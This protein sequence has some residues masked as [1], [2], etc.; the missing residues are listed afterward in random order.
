VTACGVVGVGAIGAGMVRS[1]VRAGFPVSAYDLDPGARARA[2]AAGAEP[3]ASLVEL[4][5]FAEV[6]LLALPDTP[7]IEAALDGG[8]EAGLR[9][10]STLVITSTVSPLTPLELER[11]LSPAGVEVLDA[12]VSGGPLR[13]GS[14]ELAIMV[15][16]SAAVFERRRPVLE[17]L[18]SHLVHVGPTGQGEIAKLVNNLMGAVIVLGIAEGLSLAAA[19]GADVERLCDAVAGGSGSSWILREWIPETVFRGDYERRFSLELMR[20]DMRLIAALAGRLDVSVPAL[21]LAAASFE[22]AI[23]AGYGGFDFSVVVALH[24][25]ASGTELPGGPPPA[26]GP[27]PD[28]ATR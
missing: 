24:A 9:P 27:A 12:P 25:Q 16:G 26:P 14:G 23:A 17:A 4:A 28:P 6:V 5:G 2:A 1:L 19:A 18:A 11:R 8:L 3:A 7:E 22:R 15:G 21:E 13:A 20:K 10:G